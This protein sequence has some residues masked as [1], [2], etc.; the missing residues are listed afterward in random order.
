M[1]N[2][3]SIKK[4]IAKRLLSKNKMNEQP[5]NQTKMI[6]NKKN[7]HTQNYQIDKKQNVHLCLNFNGMQ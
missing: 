3:K 1:L 4:E 6:G 5:R 2:V 7:T